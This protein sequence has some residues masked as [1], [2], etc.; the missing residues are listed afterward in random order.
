MKIIMSQIQHGIKALPFLLLLC[1]MM[2]GSAGAQDEM[3]GQKKERKRLW[4]R[5][6]KNRQSYNPYLE[7]SKRDKPSARMARSQKR[8]MR[9]QNRAAKRQLRRSKRTIR[10]HSKIRS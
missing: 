5:W 10:K 9:K 6:R 3:V 2:P 4:K 8:E 7:K 1:F